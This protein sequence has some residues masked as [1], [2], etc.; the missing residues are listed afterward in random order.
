MSNRCFSVSTS[1]LLLLEKISLFKLVIG[2]LL[3]R[4]AILINKITYVEQ[5]KTKVTYGKE[6][7]KETI[8]TLGIHNVDVKLYEGVSGKIKVDVIG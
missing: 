7:L 1:E 5:K 3:P 6:E 4:L 2:L 8:K